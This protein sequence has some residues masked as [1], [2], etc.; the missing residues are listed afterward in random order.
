MEDGVGSLHKG[1]VG[2]CVFAGV[3]VAVKAGEVAAA[4]FKANP[5]ALE[6][7]VAGGPHIDFVLVDLAGDNGFGFAGGGFAI[8]GAEDAFGQVDRCAI[9]SYI[10]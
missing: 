8:P 1:R 5:V 7:D 4:H 2:G 10:D 6:K 9:G 3:Q